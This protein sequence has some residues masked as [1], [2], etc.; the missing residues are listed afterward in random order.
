MCTSKKA[1]A[2]KL[3]PHL[4]WSCTAIPIVCLLT[5]SSIGDAA[6]TRRSQ[7]ETQRVAQGTINVS[8]APLGFK[9][10]ET[11]YHTGAI[12]YGQALVLKAR[13]VRRPWTLPHKYRVAT[14]SDTGAVVRIPRCATAVLLEA[15]RVFDSLEP[16]LQTELQR[17]LT[18]PVTQRVF[19]SPGGHF[20]LHYDTSGMSAVPLAD[21]DSNT[22]PDYIERIALYADS[23]W[24][25]EV[26]LFGYLPP[27]SDGL[28]GG[29][30]RYDIYFDDITFFGFTQPELFGPASWNDATSYIV[31]RKNFVG[32]TVNSDPEGSEIGAAKVTI[33]HEFQHAVQ[34]AYDVSDEVW[35]MESSATWM[36]EML[37]DEVNDNYNYFPEFQKTPQTALTREQSPHF[38]AT[39]I[40]PLYLS[41][42]YDT[43]LIRQAW[44]GARFKDVMAAIADSLPALYGV[45]RDSAFT[46]F[47]VWSYLTAQRDDGQH[48]EEAAFYPPMSIA[49]TVTTLPVISQQA[50]AKPQGYAS[51]FVSFSP[52]GAS[53]TLEISFQGN[54]GRNWN[55]TVVATRGLND[56][57]VFTI[58]LNNSQAGTLFIP[59]HEQYSEITLIGMNLTAYS[60]SAE[61]VY[62]ASI[63]SGAAVAGV[64]VTDSIAYTQRDNHIGFRFTNF[65][66][67]IDS[68]MLSANDNSGWDVGIDDSS[69]FILLPGAD[70][71]VIT[72]VI[73]PAGTLPGASS[74]VSINVESKSDPS[75]SDTVTA[76]Q[77][78]EIYRGD[79]N[80]DGN[81][82]LVDA[83][84]LIAWMF[85]GGPGPLPETIAADATCNGEV[86]L[87]DVVFLIDILFRGQSLPFCNVSDPL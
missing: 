5:L 55:A 28:E 41:Q 33:A 30:S 50:T 40:W 6:P 16:T 72:S 52:T 18:R 9:A 54:V 21:A 35:F 77:V 32:L 57:D 58:D 84:Y 60:V 71:T 86:N 3:R 82:N 73:P 70:T 7:Q 44:E 42:R 4:F 64:T 83:T 66:V 17:V 61:F 27:P 39:F 45:T 23:S 46:E 62:S 13:A 63:V 37:F 67:G 80:W 36:E 87:E 47:I 12:T 31:L 69:S 14:Q 19:D 59:A 11:D 43:S 10:I 24:R 74:T 79:A 68:F 25:G 1:T 81:I 49:D 34:F 85:S 65:G 51:G 2:T 48:F 56:H 78:V 26:E 75:A 53:G 22:V 20:K 8:E 15:R 76:R 38:Y 29:D